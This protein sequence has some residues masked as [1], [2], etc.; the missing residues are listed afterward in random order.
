MPEGPEIKRAADRIAK[1]IVQ[2]PLTQ[3]FFAF[4][5]LKH[6]EKVFVQERLVPVKLRGKAFLPRFS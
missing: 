2:K 6:Y 3:V 1:A 4:D 5:D